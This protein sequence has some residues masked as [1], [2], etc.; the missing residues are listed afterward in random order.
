MAA[1]LL[2][3]MLSSLSSCTLL[4]LAEGT[5]VRVDCSPSAPLP[6]P[7][8]RTIPIRYT[9]PT[10][11]QNGQPLHYLSHTTIYYNIGAGTKEYTKHSATSVAGGGPVAREV[12]LPAGAGN[13]PTA[14]IC[15]TATNSAGEG[16]PTF[17]EAAGSAP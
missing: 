17:L 3:I 11:Q 14:K 16:S 8:N 6:I 13:S 7:A 12:I 2:P 9:E 5:S 4:D 10:L 15:V 1:I